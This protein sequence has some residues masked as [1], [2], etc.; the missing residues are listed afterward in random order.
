MVTDQATR[1]AIEYVLTRGV[2][3]VE[4]ETELRHLLSTGKPLRIKLGVDPSHYD[5]TIGHAVVFRKLR[6]FQRLGH[7][8]VVVIGDWTARLGDPSEREDARK[9]LTAEQ[10]KDHATTYLEQFFRIVDPELTEVH[11]QSEWYNN[12]DLG[13][14]VKL[15]SHK[16]VAQ[17]LARDDFSKRY[18]SGVEIYLSEFMYPLLQ[19]YDSVALHAD[20]EIGGTDQTFN[21]LVGRE[22][23]PDFGQPSQQ[24]LTV[25][26]IVG[27]DGVKKMGK[28]LSNYIAMT[29]PAKDMYGKLMSLPDHAMMSYF[30]TLTDVP[31]AELD[32]FQ[33]GIAEGPLN[34]RDVKMRMAREIVSEFHNPREAQ[35]AEEAFVSQFSERALP[36]NIPEFQLEKPMDIVTLMVDAKLAKSKGEAR[37]LIQQGG[38][39]LFHDENASEAQRVN[40]IDFMVPAR[41]GAIVKVGKL[42]YIRIKQ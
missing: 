20:V 17:M 11:W 18:K 6:Q 21:L 37:R 5:L 7:K 28:S 33:R 13:D 42:K 19:G 9:P 29:A 3:Q 32:V 30:E 24:I 23:Q 2:V 41:D 31:Q 34:P 38:V 10:V 1:E 12:F 35:E 16:T 40:D 22:L 14:A 4:K 25:Q 27:L 39:S 8:A 36:T 15:Q 26:L